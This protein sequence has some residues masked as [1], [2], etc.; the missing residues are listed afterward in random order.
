[1][2]ACASVALVFVMVALGVVFSGVFIVRR[3]FKKE[4]KDA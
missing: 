2:L 4:S 3:V 1:M